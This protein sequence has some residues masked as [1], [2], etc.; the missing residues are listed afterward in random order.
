[1]GQNHLGVSLFDDID[2]LQFQPAKLTND[3]FSC[4]KT[5]VCGNM[6]IEPLKKTTPESYSNNLDVLLWHC[7]SVGLE[8]GAQ[9]WALACVFAMWSKIHP[10]R[11]VIR[12]HVCL[13]F[14][15]AAWSLSFVVAITKS[16]PKNC[17]C[18]CQAP[19]DRSR[20]SVLTKRSKKHLWQCNL[21]SWWLIAFYP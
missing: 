20:R 14:S 15:H 2:S 16:V 18:A 7:R 12:G 3:H 9:K 11:S 17:N 19:K 21:L 5:S 10:W 4:L 8:Q 13:W 6:K 1:M